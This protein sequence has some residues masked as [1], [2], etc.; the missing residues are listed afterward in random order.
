MKCKSEIKACNWFRSGHFENYIIPYPTILSPYCSF[1]GMAF[2][3]LYPPNLY[4]MF[5]FKNNLY[6][7]NLD[8]QL[9][10]IQSVKS[11]RDR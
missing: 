11:N 7:S 10:F 9:L 4:N 1:A 5:D 8:V 3:L 2:L 6:A